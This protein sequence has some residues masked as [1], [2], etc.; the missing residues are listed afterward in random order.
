MFGYGLSKGVDID[1][2]G[3]RDIAIG[4]P[5]SETV[6]VFKSY[7]VVKVMASISSSKS[8]VLLEER[9]VTIKVCATLQTTTEIIHEVDFATSLM[10]DVQYSRASFSPREVEK[11]L[12]DTIK[13]NQEERCNDYLIHLG[14][15][16][17]D[18]FKPLLIEFRYEPIKGIPEY[19]QK[20]CDTCVAMD[21][22]E[23]KSATTKIAFS[24]GCSEDRC[25]SDLAVVG[26]LINVRQPYVLGS[27]RTIEIK[28][29]I[30]N[31]GE[32]SYLTQL[33]IQIPSNITEFSR[34]P[35]SCRQ[36]ANNHGAMICDINN[37]IP[38]KNTELAELTINLDAS[39]LEGNSLKV[40]ANVS[41]AADES[42]PSDNVYVNEIVLTEFSDVELNG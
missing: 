9:S 26:T 29:E 10:L 34:I 42:R 15:T 27:T 7:P 12:N 3:Y 30:S 11:V 14:G 37:G 41:S 4:S 13:L 23:S 21:P 32:S 38:L 22:N 31:S 35:P 17:H 18:I 40:F 2:N 8:E 28:Y 6:Y 1:S 36:D 33:F 24:T 5:A 20:F 25:V 39:R 19:D 16:L